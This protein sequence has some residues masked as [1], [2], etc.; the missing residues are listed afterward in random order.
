MLSVTITDDDD[1]EDDD[2]KPSDV[3]CVANFIKYIVSF[4]LQKN[5]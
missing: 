2:E 3:K 5:V 1:D 4:V